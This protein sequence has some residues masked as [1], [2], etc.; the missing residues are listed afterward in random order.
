VS[1]SAVFVHQAKIVKTLNEK[2]ANAERRETVQ[3][4]PFR[5]QRFAYPWRC[6]C[7]G[8]ALQTTRNTP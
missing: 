8:S 1:G 2:T 7:R 3:R 4:L 5:I 6:L